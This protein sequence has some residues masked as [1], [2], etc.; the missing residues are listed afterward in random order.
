VCLIATL[1]ESATIVEVIQKTKPFVHQIVV[2]DGFSQDLTFETAA[3]TG[4]DVIYQEGTG[5][6]LALRTGLDRF[7][8]DIYVTIDGDATYDPEEM[9]KLLRPILDDD[10]D[11]VIGSRLAGTIEHGSISRINTLGNRVFNFLINW[12]FGGPITDSQSGFR[13][14]NRRV[15]DAFTL[16]SQSF[17][18]ETEL[19]VKA[20]QHGFR[21]LE[22]PI[23][24]GKRRG[25]PSKLSALN[26][27]SRIFRTILTCCFN[28]P[29]Q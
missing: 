25:T 28:N 16:S 1:N 26:A 24:Y 7:D 6:G 18:I 5:K 21:V 22:I 10:A 3:K 20:L 2:I 8:A 29:A 27:G 15:V 23:T 13:A 4:V 17:E 12:F 14:F 11:M 19:T 9:G